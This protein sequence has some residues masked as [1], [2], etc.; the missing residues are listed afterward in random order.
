MQDKLLVSIITSVLF[1]IFKFMDIQMNKKSQTP[2]QNAPKV[3][4]RETGLVFASI[5]CGLYLI[6][7]FGILSSRDTSVNQQVGAFTDD[8]NF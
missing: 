8:P 7:Y 3:L 6:E 5:L 1:L 4:I 2:T